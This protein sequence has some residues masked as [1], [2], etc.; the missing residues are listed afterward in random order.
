MS[1]NPDLLLEYSVFK[2]GM[3]LLSLVFRAAPDDAAQH[4]WL[5]IFREHNFLNKDFSKIVMDLLESHKSESFPLPHEF[6]EKEDEIEEERE[7]IK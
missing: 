7:K 1:K 3:I 2:E 5:S 6:F 4:V